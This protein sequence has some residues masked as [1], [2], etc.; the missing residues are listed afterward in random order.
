MSSRRNAA[1][2]R[3]GVRPE[4]APQARWLGVAALGKG[5]A[6]P[7]EPR[8]DPARLGC[9]ECGF[10]NDCLSIDKPAMKTT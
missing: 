2:V 8:L 1:D 7:G 4:G 6:I 9:S 5:R 10:V 3:P